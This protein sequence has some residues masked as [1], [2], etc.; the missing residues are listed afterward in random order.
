MAV[1]VGQ[2]NVPDTP[3]NRQLD[4]CQKAMDLAIHTIKITSNQKIFKPEFQGALTNEII[5]T[6]KNVYTSAWSANNVYVTK[7]NK[8]WKERERLQYEAVRK[9]NEL[10]AL[11]NIARRLLHLKGKKAKYWSELA[12]EA[13]RL[14][15]RWHEANA[16]QYGA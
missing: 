8:R 7:E 16:E 4:A 5:S 15:V 10:V 2:R 14:I 13:R 11:I 3:G 9:C 1:N 12:I 6:A